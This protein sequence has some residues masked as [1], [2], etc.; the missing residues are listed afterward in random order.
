MN[1]IVTPPKNSNSIMQMT[2][3]KRKVSLVM[4]AAFMMICALCFAIP[5]QAQQAL[6]MTNGTRQV[7]NNG[8]LFY[9]SGGPLLFDP[10]TDPENANEYNWTTWYQHNEGYTLTLT[11]PEGNGVKVE[12]S[13]LLINNDF[14]YFY[15]GDVVDVYTNDGRWIAVGHI[16][17]GSIAVRVLSFKQEKIDADFWQRRL[18]VPCAS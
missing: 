2:R 13:K 16:Q 11:V 7:P 17:V 10:A 8:F 15:E 3:Q 5:A 12:F 4:R 9:D 1:Q 6:K 14:L 18:S